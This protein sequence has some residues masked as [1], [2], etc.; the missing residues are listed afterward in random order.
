MAAVQ[1][2]K[3][4]IFIKIVQEMMEVAGFEQCR[5]LNLSG[6]INQR[7]MYFDDHPKVTAVC[8]DFTSRLRG[9]IASMLSYYP[10]WIVGLYRIRTLVVRML[11]LVQHAAPD[12]LPDLNFAQLVNRS[13]TGSGDFIVVLLLLAPAADAGKAS[14]TGIVD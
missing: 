3:R 1:L 6:G 14:E 11:G 7:R 8:Q 9:M 13:I 2:F 5:Y 12:E 4:L 10:W